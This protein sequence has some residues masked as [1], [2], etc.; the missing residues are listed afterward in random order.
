MPKPAGVVGAAGPTATLRVAV[1]EPAALLA[2]RVTVNVPAAEYVW[3]GF[4]SELVPPSPKAQDH[5]VGLPLLLSENCTLWFAVGE[6]GDTA[7]A[8]A[9]G[10]PPGDVDDD[11]PSPPPHAASAKTPRRSPDATVP[12]AMADGLRIFT[13]PASNL[14]RPRCPSCSHSGAAPTGS[15]HAPRR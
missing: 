13:C 14:R 12:R 11:D 3:L 15:L 5:A 7:N 9:G 2:I 8:A 1:V 4:W 10:V 6:D